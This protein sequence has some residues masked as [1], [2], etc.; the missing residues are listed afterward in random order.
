MNHSATNHNILFQ[1]IVS[2]A[3][4]F[5]RKE[6]MPATFESSFLATYWKVDITL[7]MTRVFNLALKSPNHPGGLCSLNITR[8]IQRDVSKRGNER[9]RC[10]VHRAA[11]S[12][13][14]QARA[15]Q[16]VLVRINTVSEKGYLILTTVD[17]PSK[18]VLVVSSF[19]VSSKILCPQLL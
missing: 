14:G 4:F 5:H 9:S 19:V 18:V 2:A 7:S 8:S 12:L 1:L 17:P 16:K 15:G 13:N 3:A 10:S 6:D 11:C